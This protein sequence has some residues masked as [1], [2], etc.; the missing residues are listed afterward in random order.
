MSPGLH[1]WDKAVAYYTGS[2]SSISSNDDEG[3]LLYALAN[4]QCAYF[5][6][7]SSGGDTTTGEAYVNDRIFRLFEE[8]Q[9]SILGGNCQ[10]AR[11]EK[12][13]IASLMKIPLIQGTLRYSHLLAYAKE[14]D[15]VDGAKAAAFALAV[16]P[17]VYGCD[18]ESASVIYNNLKVQNK[19]RVDFVAIK[20]AFERSYNCLNITCGQVG[21]IYDPESGQ[22]A[23]D[24]GPCVEFF[25]QPINDDEKQLA[26]ALGLSIGILAVLGT[27]VCLVRRGTEKRIQDGVE[28]S[29]EQTKMSYTDP[30]I[31]SD[32]HSLT[33]KIQSREGSA[34]SIRRQSSPPRPSSLYLVICLIIATCSCYCPT[35]ASY[36]VSVPAK[37]EACFDLTSP[38]QS[39]VL[40][41]NFDH[42]DDE[43][44]SDPVSVVVIDS[45]QQHVLYR[46]KRRSSEGE[47]K[48]D[49]KQDQKVT[50]CI[51][52]G[53]VTAGRG[54]KTPSERSHDGQDRTIGFTFSVE[55]KNEVQ[56]LSTKN[57][58]I[59]QTASD[60]TR[61]LRNLYNHHEYMRTRE[62][63]HREL[64]EMTFSQLMM[65]VILEGVTVIMIAG[66]QILYF[67]RFLERRRYM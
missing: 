39:G 18:T 33:G 6:T 14:H 47:F 44:S 64:V 57:D 61:E 30:V 48:I 9:A 34:D 23:Q 8:G 1:A 65:W 5:K 49:I 20:G 37:D 53:I 7:C 3:N 67:R 19:P 27:F 15:A 42:L 28:K 10:Q 13:H 41:G 54:R 16:L 55:P 50:L 17:V 43:L 60:L 45:Q 58:K 40:Y 4:E 46:S 63:K 51:Q 52:N 2:L 24:A 38:G 26:L 35:E 66:G 25:G 11:I 32:D 56:E 59:L 36:V 31:S 62:G 12:Q 21:G 29:W 22:Y